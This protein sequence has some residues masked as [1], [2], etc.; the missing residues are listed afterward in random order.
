MQLVNSSL[1]TV[2]KVRRLQTLNSQAILMLLEN[3]HL[4]SQVDIAITIARQFL[5]A[6][7]LHL[8]GILNLLD[9]LNILFNLLV[10]V[11]EIKLVYVCRVKTVFGL[12][13]L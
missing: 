8:F 1:G 5:V 6:L 9:F 11:K 2:F 7:Y 13:L 12:Q 10:H 4:L 3:L